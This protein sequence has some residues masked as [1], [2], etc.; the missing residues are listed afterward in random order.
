MRAVRSRLSVAVAHQLQPRAPVPLTRLLSL[1]SRASEDHA[2]RS[3]NGTVLLASYTAARRLVPS[4]LFALGFY[5]CLRICRGLDWRSVWGQLL[6]VGP[7][8][9]LLLLAPCV[10]NFLHMLGWRALLD[11]SFRPGLLRALLIFVAAQAGNTLGAS[12]LGESVKVVAFGTRRRAEALHI[13]LWDNLTALAALIPLLL[14]VFL[15]PLR[16]AFGS[17]VEN[18]LCAFTAVSIVL[19]IGGTVVAARRLPARPPLMNLLF[20]VF[21]HGLGKLWIVVEFAIALG[22]L[23]TV[24]WYSSALLGFASTFATSVGA[25]V[26]GQVG[27]LEAALV[28]CSRAAHLSVTTVIAVATLRRVRSLLWVLLGAACCFALLDVSSFER[29]EPST[30]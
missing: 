18:G 21:A 25:P 17:G 5:L 16:V 24:S 15:L 1:L 13:V 23:A 6:S 3:R 29:R 10:G 4:V 27:I 11:R 2:P 7:A 26:P 28:A 12:V 20:A 22:L 30:T 14:S 19:L 8:V 9:I